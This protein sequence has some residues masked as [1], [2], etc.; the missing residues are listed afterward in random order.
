[1][2]LTW[3][4]FGKSSDY[5]ILKSTPCISPVACKH[6]FVSGGLIKN[7]YCAPLL[8]EVV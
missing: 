1:M 2:S 3:Q 4:T 7:K 5:F 8:P 6:D